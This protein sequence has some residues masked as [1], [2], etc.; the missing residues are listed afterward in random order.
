MSDFNFSC[1]KC[2]EPKTTIKHGDHVHIHATSVN[3]GSAVRVIMSCSICGCVQDITKKV[4]QESFAT[5][6]EILKE[7]NEKVDSEFADKR[8]TTN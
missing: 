4:K 3:Y 7:K 2:L 5:I 8:H 1:P 6:E